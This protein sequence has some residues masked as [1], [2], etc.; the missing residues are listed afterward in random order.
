[1]IAIILALILS[2]LLQLIIWE[3]IVLSI[4]WLIET[5]A[6]ININYGLIGLVVFVIWLLVLIIHFLILYGAYKETN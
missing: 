2:A 5:F 4:A 3:G 6:G 1:M